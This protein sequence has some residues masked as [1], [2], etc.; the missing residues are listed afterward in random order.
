MND[1]GLRFGLNTRINVSALRLLFDFF[2]IAAFFCLFIYSQKRNKKKKSFSWLRLSSIS[3]F[4]LK[5]H[6]F[7]LNLRSLFRIATVVVLDGLVVF[8]HSAHH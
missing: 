5:E 8:K 6:L 2:I 1:R 3:L 7:C 4:S